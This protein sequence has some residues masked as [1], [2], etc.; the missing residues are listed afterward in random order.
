MIVRLRDNFD[1]LDATVRERTSELQ[2]ANRRLTQT[3]EKLESVRRDL[4]Q[5]DPKNPQIIKT[6]Y[7]ASYLLAAEVEWQEP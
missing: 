1:N 5:A 6:V 3:V 4:A 2:D 7:G